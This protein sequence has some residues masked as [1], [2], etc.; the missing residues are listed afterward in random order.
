MTFGLKFGSILFNGLIEVTRKGNLEQ[1][2]LYLMITELGGVMIDRNGES[3]EE[4]DFKTWAQSRDGEEYLITAKN[5][6]VAR[7]VL[8]RAKI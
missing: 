7:Q 1:P 5:M 8:T 3:A 4:R 2:A 6:T